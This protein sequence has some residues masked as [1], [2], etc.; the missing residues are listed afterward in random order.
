MRAGDGD[1]SLVTGDRRDAYVPDKLVLQVTELYNG[2]AHY[3][4]HATL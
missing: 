2:G 4:V 1:R 3:E